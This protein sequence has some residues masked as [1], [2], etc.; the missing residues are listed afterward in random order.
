MSV[1]SLKSSLNSSHDESKEELHRRQNV[2]EF[3]SEGAVY[4]AFRGS[5]VAFKLSRLPHF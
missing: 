4:P 1:A 5:A 3:P 2:A